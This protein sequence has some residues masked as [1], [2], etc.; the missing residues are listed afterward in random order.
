MTHICIIFAKLISGLKEDAMKWSELKKILVD[1]GWYCV[2]HGARHDL[3]AHRQHDFIIAV[4]R[5]D[6]EEVAKGTCKQ[7]LKRIR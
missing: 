4:G 5:H 7:I 3:Y 1:E 6:S 2:R